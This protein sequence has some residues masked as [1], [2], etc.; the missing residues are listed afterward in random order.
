MSH[1]DRAEPIDRSQRAAPNRCGGEAGGDL[2]ARRAVQTVSAGWHVGGRGGMDFQDACAA[3]LAA[4]AAGLLPV[5]VAWTWADARPATVLTRPWVALASVAL[6]SVALAWVARRRAGLAIPKPAA[7]AMLRF[8]GIAIL[9]G[10][11]SLTAR[12]TRLRRRGEAL[13]SSV[14]S[15]IDGA[16]DELQ[17]GAGPLVGVFSGRIGADGEVTSPAGVSCAFYDATVR[18]ARAANARRGILSLA[19]DARRLVWIRGEKAHAAVAFST[20][21]LH[22]PEEVRRCTWGGRLALAA[23]RASAGEPLAIDAVS[24]ERVGRIGESCFVFGRLERGDAPG[25]Y[26][27]RGVSGGAATLLV[28]VSHAALGRAWM[29]RSWAHAGGAAILTAFAASL[30]AP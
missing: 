11:A 27:I 26:V 25:S 22:A 6:A 24:H 29:I 12:A 17:R 8:A 9:A 2:P 19:R 1:I 7:D 16:V 13:A 15:A 10:A 3:V 14:A 30:L 18:Q 20:R 28:G 5:A 21:Q 23:Q 4:A